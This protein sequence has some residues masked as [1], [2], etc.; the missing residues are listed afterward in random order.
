[1]KTLRL[2]ATGLAV[3]AAVIGMQVTADAQMCLPSPGGVSG[4]DR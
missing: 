1:M 3:S 2:A 4:E